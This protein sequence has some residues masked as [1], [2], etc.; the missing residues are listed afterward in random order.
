MSE[1]TGKVAL[2]T[3]G[4]LGIGAAIA[5]HFAA[6]GAEVM[7]GD[8]QDDLGKSVAK[9]I[10]ENGGR[11][12]YRHQDVAAEADWE[13]TVAEAVRT[14]GGLDVLVNNAGME[15]ASFLADV[16]IADAQRQLTV[17][18]VGTILGLKHA[19]RA[20]R[21]GGA[22]GKGGSII[23]LSSVAGLIGTPGLG[24]YSAS[25]GGVRLL[26]KAAA[27][28]CGVLGYNIR[29]NSIHPG[30]VETQMGEKLMHD[31]VALGV[32]PD[33]ATARK[34]HSAGYPIGRTGVPADIA[35]AALFLASDQSSW[36]TGTE[37]VVDGG[38]TMS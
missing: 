36:I 7:I 3:G 16:V 32:F 4:A 19:I 9:E 14:F 24:I 35:N 28:E 23:N 25:K 10:C 8:I 17:N 13:E 31:F 30:F 15:Q 22:A 29:V 18:L 34:Q 37:L 2:V 6:R 33:L 27:A 1:L 20:M 11:A 26:S 21:P 12:A 38:L 5:R